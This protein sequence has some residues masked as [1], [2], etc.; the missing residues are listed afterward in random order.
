[1]QLIQIS[2]N[3]ES[4]KTLSFTLSL[5]L[6]CAN[7]HAQTTHT[8]G[9]TG[10]AFSTPALDVTLGDTVDFVWGSGVHNVRADSGAYDSGP[11]VVAP[12][13]YSVTFDQALLNAYPISDN[14]YTYVCD[15]HAGFG[16][17]GFIK[18]LTPG[19]PVLS[20]VPAF[21]TAGAPLAFH[22][23][24]AAPST[25]LMLGYSTAG[26]GPFSSPYG[27]ALLTPPVALV[28]FL[29]TGAGGHAGLGVTVPSGV[30]GLTVWFQ[31]LD[32]SASVFSNGAR[33]VFL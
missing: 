26:G 20:L 16:M 10:V 7:L 13:T 8:V 3:I 6:L 31:A 23:F 24:D 4:M 12:F 21:P 25:V 9:V 17:V 5:F 32:A 22:V 28:S 11:P 30:A 1:M 2:A 29:Q 15:I 27:I 19:T 18:V 33:V 14:I